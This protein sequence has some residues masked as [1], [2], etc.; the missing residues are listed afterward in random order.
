LAQNYVGSNNINVLEPSGNFGSRLQ[1]GSDA[2]SARYIHTRLS[3]L[4]RRVY[5]ILDE[6]VLEHQYEDGKMIEPKTYVPV[7][8]MVLVNG[9][10]GIGTG[11][12]TDI[13]NYHPMEIVKNLK[14]RMGRLEPGDEEEKPFLPMSPWFRGWNGVVEADGN[15][16]KFNGIA[17]AD[18]TNNEVI[19]T[20]L[21]IRMWTDD[22]KAKLE[23]IIRAEK[24]PSWIKDYKEFNDHKTVHFVIQM[25]E[26]HLQAA[27]NEGLLEKFKLNK[28]IGITN[29]VAFDTQGRIRKYDSPDQIMEEY[30][31]YRMALY[32]RRKAYWL[33][34]FHAA[35]RKLQNQYRFVHEI[36]DGKLVVSKKK[37]AVLVEELRAKKYEAFPKEDKKTKAD[38]EEELETVD[39]EPDEST[40]S[41]S[42]YDYLLSVS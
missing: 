36:I 1:G 11:W 14:R 12:S 17:Q 42:D 37:K 32:T 13:P 10:S 30:F 19:I 39:L 5:S 26:K 6:P 38:G 16:F 25:E 33:K 20:E 9:A 41:A 40:G 22:F 23:E 21:P 4:A 15:K 31:H 8:P 7:I 24:S 35:F 2:A 29:L 27:V 18:E 34:V 28:S 3:P